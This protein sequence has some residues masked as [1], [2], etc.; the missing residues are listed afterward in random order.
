MSEKLY[1]IK[2]SGCFITDNYCNI[3]EVY[4]NYGCAKARVD[5]FV[6]AGVPK[7]SFKIHTYELKTRQTSDTDTLG[8]CD[9]WVEET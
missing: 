9:Y 6:K 2:C 4:N 8:I 5:Y 3:Q 7:D 1:V